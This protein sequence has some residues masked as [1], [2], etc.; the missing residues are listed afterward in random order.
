MGRGY[1]EEDYMVPQERVRS[2]NYLECDPSD[3]SRGG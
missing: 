2:E 1:L 3:F